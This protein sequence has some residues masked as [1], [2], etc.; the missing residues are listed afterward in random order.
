MHSC[1]CGGGGDALTMCA[2]V[3]LLHTVSGG[4][5]CDC[6]V[7]VFGQKKLRVVKYSLPLTAPHM[8]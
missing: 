6:C 7:L 1:V 4:L 5:E 3:P 2:Y 8:Q